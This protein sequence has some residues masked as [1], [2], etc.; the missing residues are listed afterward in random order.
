MIDSHAW[1]MYF[2]SVL[3]E[4]SRSVAWSGYVSTVL[5]SEDRL[6]VCRLPSPVCR[7]PAFTC[8]PSRLST[9]S[10]RLG[11]FRAE[12]GSI[13]EMEI[14]GPVAVVGKLALPRRS[15]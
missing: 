2:G 7:L 9:V 15:P 1:F 13:G 8:F 12:I 10:H 14:F 11:V 4:T 3:R 5:M 6:F